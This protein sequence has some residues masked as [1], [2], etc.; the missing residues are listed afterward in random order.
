MA[1]C[2]MKFDLC[3]C[4]LINSEIHTQL[5]NYINMNWPTIS[6]LKSTQATVSKTVLAVLVTSLH[7]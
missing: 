7:T 4:F 6:I 5:H 2:I 1:K 3:I